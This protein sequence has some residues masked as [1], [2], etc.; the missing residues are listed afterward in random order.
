M[1]SQDKKS[2]NIEDMDIKQSLEAIWNMMN[3]AASKGAFTI[4]ES[5]ILKVLF[6]K[7]SKS[8]PEEKSSTD[9]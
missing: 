3:R 1:E 9:V 8:I 4:D 5:Y 6:S 7:V 2:I